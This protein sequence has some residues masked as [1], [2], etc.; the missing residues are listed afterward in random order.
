M[1]WWAVGQYIGLCGLMVLTVACTVLPGDVT[2]APRPPVAS[3]AASSTP[4]VRP[5]PTAV[6]P[7]PSPTSAS[8]ESPSPTASPT[9]TQTSTPTATDTPTPTA[10]PS[11][12][13]SPTATS[14]PTASPGLYAPVERFGLGF[15]RGF[16]SLS[17]YPLA[18]LPFGWYADWTLQRDPERP[19]GV[20]YVQTLRVDAA[21]WPPDWGFV[22]EVARRNPGALWLIGNEPECIYQDA[23]SPE[24]YAD[25][26][27]QCYTFLKAQDPTCRVAIGGVVEATPLRLAWLGQLWAVYRQRYGQ[28]MLVDVWNMHNQILKEKRG[29][30]GC[31]IPVGLTAEEGQR[32]PWWENDSLAHFQAHVWAMR[33]WMA[34]HGQRDK[35]LIIS[36]YGV[37]M[38]NTLFDGLAGQPK[39][40]ERVKAFMEGTFRFLLTAT[41]PEIGCPADG[42]RLV[43]RWLWY[44][45]N[46]PSWEQISGDNQGFNGG[47]V[48]PYTHQLTP[49]GR[50]Y[51]EL[52]P[53]LLQEFSGSGSASQTP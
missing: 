44:S 26:Y 38:P 22:A 45:L 51:A 11:P 8:E 37:L 25:I 34:A 33:R 12:T 35:P 49:Y 53:A 28:E 15:N 1:R 29:D 50:F 27:H 42:N 2:M 52:V 43:Q 5:K 40:E 21:H 7:S 9:P 47:L 24:E 3:P 31:D 41:D 48:D 30:Y 14:T 36:E 18:Q 4:S 46:A 19:G 10:T 39:G 23:R 17:D 6:L 16:G 20:E 32:Y 13:P